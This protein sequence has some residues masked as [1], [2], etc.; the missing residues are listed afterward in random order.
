DR[1]AR[2]G[3][4]GG[5]RSGPATR[6]AVLARALPPDRGGGGPRRCLRCPARLPR[7]DLRRQGLRRLVRQQRRHR[8]AHRLPRGPAR[9]RRPALD[10]GHRRARHP[11]LQQRG[12]HPP[13][14]VPRV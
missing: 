1:G 14:P 11:D 3:R 12:R 7:R 13:P 10:R 5:A 6:G 8:G 2:A 9:R 4:R